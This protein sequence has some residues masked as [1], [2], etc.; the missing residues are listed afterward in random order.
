MPKRIPFS[1]LVKKVMKRDGVSLAVASKRASKELKASKRTSVAK[2]RQT[3]PKKRTVRTKATNINIVSVPCPK[4]KRKSKVSK[5]KKRQT[6]VKRK[7]SSSSVRLNRQ[8]ASFKRQVQRRTGLVGTP[9]INQAVKEFNE[10]R[11]KQIDEKIASLQQ[12]KNVAFVPPEPR[13]LSEK[14]LS[15]LQKREERL[16]SQLSGIRSRLARQ[17]AGLSG[18]GV[19]ARITRKTREPEEVEGE[20]VLTGRARDINVPLPE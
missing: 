13:V 3:K 4:P 15:K 5:T 18:V 6:Q 20:V 11:K 17:P 7:R 16:T 12:A 14:S 10:L 19:Q 2:K 8:F 1:S 9:L